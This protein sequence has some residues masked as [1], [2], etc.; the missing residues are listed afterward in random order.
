MCSEYQLAQVHLLERCRDVTEPVA[1]SGA[2][3]AF[4]ILGQVVGVLVLVDVDDRVG[5]EVDRIGAGREA[6]VELVR[7]EDLRRQRLPSPGRPAVGE[8]RPA[9]PDAAEPLFDVR[10]QLVHD[11][12]PVGA[13]VGRVHRV[14]IV[15][16]GVCVL[17]L[18]DDHARH[19]RSGP[20]FVEGVGV[21]LLDSVVALQVET[22]AVFGLEIGVGGHF[23]KAPELRGE[24]PVVDDQRI[25]SLGMLVEA[26][27]YEH[28]CAELHRPPPERRQE[29]ALDLDVLDVRRLRR[30]FDRLDHPVEARS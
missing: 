22:L 3:R 30:P 16:V 26:L 24:V 25:A 6:A 18:D 29:L 9:L 2:S 5:A 14:R 23:A 15:V 4:P 13:E 28:P 7:V 11:R 1:T 8:T 10:Q 20:L 12:V 27:G 17:D 19:V 21:L